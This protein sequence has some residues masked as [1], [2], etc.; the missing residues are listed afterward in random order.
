MVDADEAVHHT[1]SSHFRDV[2]SDLGSPSSYAVCMPR[3][4]ERRRCIRSVLISEEDG[5]PSCWK[6]L[7]SPGYRRYGRSEQ[8]LIKTER[9]L[10]LEI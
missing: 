10:I 9:R 4:E 8:W 1:K 2:V 5:F 6:T 7:K 3:R